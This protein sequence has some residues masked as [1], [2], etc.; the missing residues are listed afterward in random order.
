MGCGASKAAA[1]VCPTPENMAVPASPAPEEMTAPAEAS[2][3]L[4]QAGPCGDSEEGAFDW[5]FRVG[6]E[7]ATGDDDTS[8]MAATFSLVNAVFEELPTE[9][10]LRIIRY[11]L[12]D[13]PLVACRL[14]ST[15]RALRLTRPPALVA[16]TTVVR[17]ALGRTPAKGCWP[18]ARCPSWP[19][20]QRSFRA[21]LPRSCC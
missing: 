9:L 19:A 3:A 10:L 11:L 7:G 1:P 20:L 5:S 13:D 18:P 2:Q 21:R 4:G 12:R 17:T 15:S 16:R 6:E 14:V 8:H